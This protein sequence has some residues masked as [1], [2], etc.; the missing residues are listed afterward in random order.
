MLEVLS[1]LVR[2][3]SK[4]TDE[5]LTITGWREKQRRVLDHME[6][7]PVLI[8]LLND[9]RVANDKLKYIRSKKDIRIYFTTQ[10]K[11]GEEYAYARCLF[12]VEGKPREFRKYLGKS[13]DVDVTRV[14]LDELKKIFLMML[15]NYLEY[16]K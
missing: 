11:R 10:E 16:H 3:P 1:Q 5:E 7:D 4:A 8:K 15:K 6:N 13:E 9:F 12:N 14:D 2:K